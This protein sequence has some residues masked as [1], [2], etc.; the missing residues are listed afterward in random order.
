MDKKKGL[1]IGGAAAVVLALV[2]SIALLPLLMGSIFGTMLTMGSAGM[3]ALAE[4]EVSTEGGQCI[5][6]GPGGGAITGSQEDY[7]RTMIGVAKG[8]D[9]DEDG[10][11]IAAMVMLQ[12]SGIQNYA[13]NGEN[14]FNYDI[15]TAQGTQFWLDAAKLSL[16]KPHDAV[17]NDADSVGLYQQRPSS[18]WANTEA[19]GFT[20]ADNT[21]EA[22]ERL[23]NPEFGARGF[24]GGPGHISN[25]GLLDI[26]GWEDMELTVAAQ[27]VQGS[28]Y[29]S[30]YA[31]WEDQA[32][33]LVGANQDAPEIAG[34]DDGGSSD[35]DS[36][37]DSDSGTSTSDFTMP[38]EEG[39]YTL[40]SPFGGR[41]DP[42][43]GGRAQHNG[44]D[45]GAPMNTPIYA[46]A[47]GEVVASGSASG[48]GN[49]VVIDHSVG[50]GTFSSV[51]GHMPANSIEVSTGDTV[52]QGDEIAGVGSEGK[53]TGPHLHFEIW[54]GGRFNNGTPVDPMDVVEGNY[55]GGGGGGGGGQCSSDDGSGVSA[56]GDAASVIAAGEEHIGV[57]YS[58][59]G[60]NVDGPSEGFAQG[61]GIVG[62]DCSSFVQNMVY[63]GTGRGHML[64]R[65]ATPQYQETKGNQVASAG[66]GADKLQPGDLLFWGSGSNNIHHVAMYVGD[67]QM[68]EAPRTGLQVRITD[69]RLDGDFYAATRINYSEV[70][71]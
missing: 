29:P 45:F 66:D 33:S 10:Q 13:N 4:E 67:G 20:A 15:G 12:E 68:I 44:Q 63:N 18:G 28:A 71:P 59:G 39:T 17:G 36:G 51:Y 16:D 64:P 1:L 25:K 62:F 53:S 8:L 69:V 65:T 32:R 24:F 35:D 56:S 54:D 50:G 31:K 48:F 26:D 2:A 60:G 55:S 27:T 49:W 42:V 47:D 34:G 46:A 19:D 30:A 57:D 11:I 41:D 40:T 70:A 38:M 3:G 21:D 43:N 37:S 22:I 6:P 9:V 52:S 58:W 7:I 61:A 14:R 5:D 23:M